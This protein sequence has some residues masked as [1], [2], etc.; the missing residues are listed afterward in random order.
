M[1]QR[2]TKTLEKCGKKKL[3]SKEFFWRFWQREPIHVLII[4][5]A[6]SVKKSFS[7]S[8]IIFVNRQ[9][10]CTLK[11][12][13]FFAFLKCKTKYLSQNGKHDLIQKFNVHVPVPIF[14]FATTEKPVHCSTVLF[15]C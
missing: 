6:G 7:K 1:M 10:H 15:I 11:I 9:S 2:Y 8:C 3:R 13:I 5:K 12:Y 14:A 4:F